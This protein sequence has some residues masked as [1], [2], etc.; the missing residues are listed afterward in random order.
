M[1]YRAW[2]IVAVILW[3]AFG[4]A[5]AAAQVA[6]AGDGVFYRGEVEW[7]DG[8]VV[9]YA[10]G[11]ETAV[12]DLA[13]LGRDAWPTIR[14][15]LW[16]TTFADDGFFAGYSEPLFDTDTDEMVFHLLVDHET[17]RAV[18]PTVRQEKVFA[19]RSRFM[20]KVAD[21]NLNGSMQIVLTSR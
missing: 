12:Q 2:S 18:S 16:T 8:D 13:S 14:R 9:R 11:T 10:S 20:R 1:R 5:P 6:S 3:F 7:I 21:L 19:A 17:W 15:Y 4:P